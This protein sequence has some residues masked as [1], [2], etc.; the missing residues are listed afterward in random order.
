[1]HFS[2]VVVLVG[3]AVVVVALQKAQVESS[4]AAPSD[5]LVEHALGA[6]ENLAHGNADNCGQLGQ[7]GACSGV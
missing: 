1:M 2:S 5:G 3:I 4:A 6:I 7:L